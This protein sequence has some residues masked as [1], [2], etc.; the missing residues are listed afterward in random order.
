M[1]KKTAGKAKEPE[2][3]ET[4]AAAAIPPPERPPSSGA[5]DFGDHKFK[6]GGVEVHFRVAELPIVDLDPAMRRVASDVAWW[7]AVAGAAEQE[8]REA[9]AHYRAWRARAAEAILMAEPGLSEWKVKNRIDADSNFLI[10]KTA[11][12]RAVGV[13][14]KCRGMVD[15]YRERAAQLQSLG[16]RKRAELE[17]LRVHTPGKRADEGEGSEVDND[18]H[19]DGDDSAFPALGNLSKAMEGYDKSWD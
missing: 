17:A 16:A 12:A 14:L 3:K 15:A 6:V 18:D 2:P 1:T 4:K 19:D 9:D 13:T 7:S 10:L 5:S 11:I 8:A